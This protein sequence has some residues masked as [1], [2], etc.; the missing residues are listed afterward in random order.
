LDALQRVTEA[1]Q[2][3]AYVLAIRGYGFELG[4]PLSEK[5]G[6]N[7]EDALRMLISRLTSGSGQL[8]S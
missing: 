8:Q 1:R 4:A 3:A 7:L 2:P 5:A 6:E